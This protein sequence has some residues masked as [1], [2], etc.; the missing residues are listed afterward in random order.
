MASAER[1]LQRDEF[2]VSPATDAPAG[3]GAAAP[4]AE[5]AAAGGK[6]TH[7]LAVETSCT[8]P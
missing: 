5:D 1:F 2:R 7:E 3:E 4:P 8:G 6:R